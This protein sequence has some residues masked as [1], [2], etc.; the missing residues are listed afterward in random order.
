MFHLKKNIYIKNSKKYMHDLGINSI[1]I[2]YSRMA[3]TYLFSCGNNAKFHYIIFQFWLTNDD[4]QRDSGIFTIL[5]LIQHFWVVLVRVFS[6]KWINKWII[7]VSLS[8]F[9]WDFCYRFTNW[10]MYPRFTGNHAPKNVIRN[11]E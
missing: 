7:F 1:I 8:S 5:H 10:L 3:L 6:L 11:K 4:H 9:G 2:V